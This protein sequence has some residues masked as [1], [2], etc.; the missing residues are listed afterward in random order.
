MLLLSLTDATCGLASGSASSDAAL[1]TLALPAAG[2]SGPPAMAARRASI[3][4]R[5]WDMKSPATTAVFLAFTTLFTAPFSRFLP[6]CG[7]LIASNSPARPPESSSLAPPEG[8]G[9]GGGAGGGGGGGGPFPASAAAGGGGGGGGGGAA[10]AGGGGGGGG[11]AA[12]ASP[13]GG[14]GGAGVVAEA[15]G[16]GTDATSGSRS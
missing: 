15:A 12:A 4:S 1:A 9:G 16:A 7:F 6:S 8:G 3:L 11:A 13:G 5:I 14:G 10:A 2:S